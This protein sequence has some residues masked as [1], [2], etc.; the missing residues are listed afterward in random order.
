M[1][2]FIPV[3]AGKVLFM[4]KTNS[5]KVKLIIVMTGLVVIPVMVLSIMSLIISFNQGTANA[6]ETNDAE[7]SEVSERLEDIYS[8]NLEAL[9]SLAGSDDVIDYLEGKVTGK[10]AEDEVRRQML[11]ID[12]G[13]ADGNNI[14]IS[15]ATGQ[16]VIRTKGECV[17]VSERDYFKQPMS[18][19]TEYVSDM[20]VSKST[21]TA[22]TTFS[23]PVY[24][25]DKSKIIG[26]I[27]RNY[28]VGG[29]H[30]YLAGEIVQKRQELVVVDR[31]GTVVAHSARAV[32]ISNPESQAGNPF[33][34]DSRGDKTYGD[35]TADFRGDTWIISWK[36]LG[37]S[38]WIV[39]CCRV[40]EIA[41]ASV[42][43]T[44]G[45]QAICGVLFLI[46]GILIALRFE[47]SIV[48]PVR[49]VADSLS[50][51]AE[52]SFKR[53]DGY[54]NRKDEFGLIITHTNKVVNK[55][56]EIVREISQ[57]AGNVNQDSE[58]LAQMAEHIS[59][60]TENVSRAVQ[61]IAMG[62][63]QQAG[64]IQNATQSI[65]KIE[66]AVSNVRSSTTDLSVITERMQGVSSDSANRL[67]E[68]RK[69]SESMDRAINDISEKISATSDAVNRISGLV[70]AISN[71]ASQTNLLS[72]NASIEAARAGEAGKGFA[73][74]AEEIGKLAL[75]S[76]GSADK[77]RAEMEELL[78]ESQ[79]A[80]S[81]AVNVQKNNVNQQKVLESTFTSVNK[82]IEDIKETNRGVNKIEHNA[83]IC[84]S[85]KD[86]VVD[87]M[88]SLSAISEENAASS[89]ETGA[90]MEELSATVL[91]LS[92]NAQNLREISAVLKKEVGFFK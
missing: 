22:I 20:I 79:A 65:E 10:E 85:A 28:D 8:S 62:A 57:G 64:E 1:K 5:I 92:E 33:Y 19:A 48:D 15:D 71:I 36:K 51:L 34:T 75:D 25:K 42:Y 55:L 38:D 77:I 52:G 68:L 21:G 30:D 50:N 73:V 46:A 17:N 35:Y 86:V 29:L 26:I 13:M 82:M 80:V 40:K 47:K 58:Q 9:K 70:E 2:H 54:Q 60:N 87:A 39:A 37:T 18:G 43:R 90:S 66:E 14:A 81:M 76:N 12:E 84:V 23:V 4:S 32:D 3:S 56:E 78:R 72:L 83:D 11:V 45:I 31:T 69:S 88:S 91:S 7:A 63:T 41:L 49:D 6:K 59:E 27:Q 44:I 89:Q 67:T 16:Q 74:V 24:S 53:I 61:E